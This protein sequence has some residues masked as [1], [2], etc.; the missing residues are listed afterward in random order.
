MPLPLS[1]LIAQ[2]KEYNPNADTTLLE[3]AYHFAQERHQNQKRETGE[4]YFN[5]CTA[6]AKIL[7]DFK[8]DEETICAGLLHDTVEDTGVTPE[9]LQKEFNKGIAHMVQG[10]TKI[11]DLKFSSTDE[12]TVENWRKMLIAVAEDVRV[13]LIK[14][15]DRTHNMRTMDIMPPEKQKFKAYETITLYAPLAQRLGMVSIKTEL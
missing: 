15:A 3:K 14:L 7:L 2:F 11:S 5:H 1:E 6:V 12:E 13:I 8:M 4:P 10:V 9:Q